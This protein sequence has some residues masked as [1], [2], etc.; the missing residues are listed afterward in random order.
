MICYFYRCL[1]FFIF[2]HQ[3]EAVILV[4]SLLTPVKKDKTAAETEK[5]RTTSGCAGSRHRWRPLQL[6]STDLA[7]LLNWRRQSGPL[8]QADENGQ[9]AGSHQSPASA[10]RSVCL[11]RGGGGS[12]SPP[13]VWS[14][15]VKG[16][17]RSITDLMTALKNTI[18]LCPEIKLIYS[19]LV[20]VF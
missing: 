13:G 2:A 12:S 19:S 11:P 8:P 3:R 6:L 9:E 20:M 1:S 7:L 4:Y 18:K 10:A 15:K 16:W 5:G 17:R 14:V